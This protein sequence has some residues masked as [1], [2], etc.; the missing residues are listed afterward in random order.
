MSTGLGLGVLGGIFA[1]AMVLLVWVGIAVYL[2]IGTAFFKMFRKAKVAHAWLAYIPIL[3]LIP[4]FDTL[5]LSRMN[6]LWIISP[7]FGLLV[8]W[9]FHSTAFAVALSA[10]LYIVFALLAIFWQ[11]RLLRFF[12]MSPWWMLMLV[13]LVIPVLSNVVDIA[14]IVLYCYMGFSSTLRY[15]G[16][17]I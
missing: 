7:L 13:G 5:R 2:L 11:I 4:Y 12:N 6:L 16:P 15:I 9:I 14:F 1:G 17:S 3:Q 10:V 8:G